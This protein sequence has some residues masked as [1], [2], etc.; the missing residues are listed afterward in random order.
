MIKKQLGQ[1]LV[2]APLMNTY[3][4]LSIYAII[5]TLIVILINMSKRS[6]LS[7]VS[8]LFLAIA[9][10]HIL[11]VW[12]GWEGQIGTFVVPMW[13]SWVAIVVGLYL[14]WTG[15]KLKKSV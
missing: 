13:F 6:Y 5:N 4:R 14:S 8:F 10:L 12:Y 3:L 2:E 11:R 7:V 1:T 15:L 9:V